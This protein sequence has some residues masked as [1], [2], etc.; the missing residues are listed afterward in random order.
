VDHPGRKYY[1][2]LGFFLSSFIP[3]DGANTEE[4]TL[5]LALISRLDQAGNLKPGVAAK[6]LI[7]L[8]AAIQKRNGF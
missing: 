3:P 1:S 4:L 5:Y 8:K 7:D 6:V 2:N